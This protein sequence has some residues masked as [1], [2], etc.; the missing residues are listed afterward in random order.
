MQSKK[1][2]SERE[3]LEQKAVIQIVKVKQ[4]IWKAKLE[5][6]SEDRLVKRVYIEEARG[7]RP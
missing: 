7:K 6:M 5:Q 1:C 4:R 2:G 3:A